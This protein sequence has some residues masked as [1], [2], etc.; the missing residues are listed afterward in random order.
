[1]T[2]AFVALALVT[3][4]LISQWPALRVVDRIDVA[5]VVRERSV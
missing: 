3:A 2:P 5:R 4:A 1:L